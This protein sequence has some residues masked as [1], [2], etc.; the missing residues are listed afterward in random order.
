MSDF[1]S[2]DRLASLPPVVRR[3]GHKMP[4]T[5]GI[6]HFGPGAFHR[7][8]QASYIDTVLDHDQRWGIAAVSLRTRGTIEALERQG[9]HYT[10]GVRDAEPEWRVIAAHNRFL[11]P[12]EAGETLALLGSPDVRLV[13]TT[14]TEKGYCLAPDGTLDFDHPDIVHDLAGAAAPRSVV[15]WIVAGLAARRGAGIAPFTPVPCDNLARNGAKL[16]AALVGYAGRL[17]SELA[18]WIAGEVR[19]PATMVDSIT[20]AS[21]A[22]FLD[23]TATTLGVRDDAAVQR[24][25]FVQWVIEDQGRPLGPDLAAAGATLTTDVAGYERAKLRLLNGPHSTL[26]YAGLLLGHTSVAE[27]MGDARLAAFVAAM[28]REEIAP[29]LKAVPGLDL[30]DYIDAVLRRFRNPV[31]VHLLEQIAHDGTQKLPYRLVDTLIENR[32]AG[33]LPPRILT[34]IGAWIG[35]VMQRAR[36]GTKIIDPEG[37]FLATA[38]AEGSA[39][40][41][42]ARITGAGLLLPP[43]MAG[44]RAVTD[45]IAR[46]GDAAFAGTLAQILA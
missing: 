6:V 7:A 3:P 36:A 19:V 24:E 12:D 16:H 30:G 20:P 17:D 35:F 43:E 46:A 39:A 28:M 37:A 1:L 15:G 25:T 2:V 11:G 40:D 34:A 45:A 14:V 29:M 10:I 23:L 41:V 26:A 18:D 38:G 8:H 32:R 21:D 22:R 4:T 9:G 42:L 27:A 31:I 5:T 13:T 44:D 33:R